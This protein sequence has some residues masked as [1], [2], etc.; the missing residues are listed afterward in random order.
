M[1][2]RLLLVEP[3]R[4]I[5]ERLISRAESLALV[6]YDADF[7][8]ARTRLLADRYD[9]VVTNIRLR[10][11]N[12]LHLLHLAAA[13]RLTTRILVYGHACDAAVAR[14]A[15][16]A[17]A[18]YELQRCVH[19]ALPSYIKGGVPAAD[20]RDAER[21]DRRHLFRGGRRISDL[22]P[23]GWPEARLPARA[24]MPGSR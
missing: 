2:T 15:Q 22:Q 23:A 20:R 3:S 24:S 6:D 4:D 5:R 8:T 1:P 13:A 21:L 11:Y 17:G 12:G 9:W 16:L 19:R 18:F 7:S 14:E 10:A